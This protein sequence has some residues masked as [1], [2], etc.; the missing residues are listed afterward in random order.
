MPK[1]IIIV[2]LKVALFVPENRAEFCYMR[3]EFM[4]G[5]LRLLKRFR[6][7]V[8]TVVYV[9]AENKVSTILGYKQIRKDYLSSQ[10]TLPK[11]L[12]LSRIC[13]RKITTLYELITYRIIFRRPKYFCQYKN[14]I[15]IRSFVGIRIQHLRPVPAIG[16]ACL[17][18]SNKR[19]PFSDNNVNFGKRFFTIKIILISYI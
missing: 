9:F 8:I 5:G 14:R 7:T 2:Q 13:S 3:Y 17:V 18:N 15:V 4:E 12:S 10:E 19:I 11:L 6:I 16:I 1:R